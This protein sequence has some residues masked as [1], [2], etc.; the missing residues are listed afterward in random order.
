MRMPPNDSASRP[1]ISAVILPRS[2]KSGRSRLNA[3]DHPDG[4]Y[5][6]HDDADERELPVQVEQHA[7]RDDGGHQAPGQLHD[8]GADEV[9]DAVRVVHDARNQDA[10]LR[11]IEI[12]DRQ[13]RHVHLH[14]LP[15]VGD[16]ALRGDTEHLRQR[17]RVSA[18]TMV[19]AP[20]ARASGTRR[21]ARCLPITSS[22]RYLEVVGRTRPASRLTSIRARPSASRPRWAQISSRA[23]AQAFAM[24]VFFLGSATGCWF[25]DALTGIGVQDSGSH[26]V[27]NRDSRVPSL[28]GYRVS[29]RYLIRWGWSAAVPR[30]LCL[31]AS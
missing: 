15:H 5:R 17:E 22:M 23:S 16:R 31:S 1:E 20:A 30:R 6:E 28:Q 14:A 24:F 4:E 12:A 8:A 3:D 25:L 26:R 18:S 11:R 10:G 2:R 29:L 7:E 27:P 9:A 21:S 19:A 13:A